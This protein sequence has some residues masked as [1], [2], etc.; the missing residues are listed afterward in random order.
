MISILQ[1][2]VFPLYS[3]SPFLFSIEFLWLPWNI[4]L[5]QNNFVRF[6]IGYAG[7]LNGFF[8]YLNFLLSSGY[9]Q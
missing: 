2:W 5:S 1:S 4:L 6:H 9:Y 7:P 8:F 3:L